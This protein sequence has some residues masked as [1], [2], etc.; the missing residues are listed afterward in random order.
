MAIFQRAWSGSEH[1]DRP[2]RAA[3]PPLRQREPRAVAK[4]GGGRRDDARTLIW[5]LE[6]GGW[7]EREAGNLVALLHGLRPALSG[8]SEREIEHLRFLR[9][10]VDTGRLDH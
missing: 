2:V 9:A 10:L 7:S 4:R 8:W 6:T 5:G 3:R 1:S